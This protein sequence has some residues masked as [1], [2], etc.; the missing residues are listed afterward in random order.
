MDDQAISYEGVADTLE[1]ALRAA[2]EKIP[3][4]MVVTSPPLV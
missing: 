2:H 4:P 1:D 3:V